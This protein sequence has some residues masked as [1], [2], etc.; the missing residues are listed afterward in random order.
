[1]ATKRKKNKLI[2]KSVCL[3]DLEWAVIEKNAEMYDCSN[4][5][6]IRMMYRSFTMLDRLSDISKI[7]LLREFAKFIA[8]YYG[9][10]E[11]MKSP[12]LENPYEKDLHE[13][14]EFYP[15]I[16]DYWE[17]LNETKTN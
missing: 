5:D 2:Q 17:N 12:D 9:Q 14:M 15:S 8:Y 7:P 6:V 13:L 3:T 16:K 11:K 1:M 10:Y 4:N